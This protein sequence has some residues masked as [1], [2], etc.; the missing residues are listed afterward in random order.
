MSFFPNGVSGRELC[1]RTRNKADKR[2]FSEGTFDE[3]IYFRT[4]KK[5]TVQMPAR[6]LREMSGRICQNTETMHFIM[7]FKC[8]SGRL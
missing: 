4:G 3:V 2:A 6:V 8:D 5:Q 1:E 7:D